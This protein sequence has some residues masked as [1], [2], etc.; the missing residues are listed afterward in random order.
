MRE[1]W[2]KNR[3]TNY[4]TWSY[5]ESDASDSHFF[6]RRI[7]ARE[8]DAVFGRFFDNFAV[9]LTL[10]NGIICSIFFSKKG[11][12]TRPILKGVKFQWFFS[13][14]RINTIYSPESGAPDSG[15][16]QRPIPILE[17]GEVLSRKNLKTASNDRYSK[18]VYF[19]I[20]L[21][22]FLCKLARFLSIFFKS[23][24][25]GRICFL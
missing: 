17:S 3:Q 23:W 20:A 8:S 25:K 16:L 5:N 1:K 13:E 2:Q 15:I 24:T 10:S 9:S 22:H 21:G 18:P 19:L 12:L 6:I 7:L 11:V 4:K 14:T